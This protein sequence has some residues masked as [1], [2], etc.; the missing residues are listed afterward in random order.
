MK[1][2]FYLGMEVHL[3]GNVVGHHAMI[4]LGCVILDSEMLQVAHFEVALLLPPGAIWEERWMNTFWIKYPKTLQHILDTAKPPADAM[5][6]FVL[7]IDDMDRR[8]G[9]SLV[10]LSEK[11]TVDVAW[12]NFYLASFTTRPPLDF[13]YR[14]DS[15]KY[16]L[17]R[18]WDTSSVYHGALAVRRAK[19]VDWGLEQALTIQNPWWSGEDGHIL[20]AARN[21]AANYLLF[22]QSIQ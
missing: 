4:G 5:A 9:P 6:E 19:I 13:A 2:R 20:N 11:I 18:I 17:R 3:T 7:W 16:E 21:V 12:I 10:L 1:G 22:L 14:Y 8:Y 15:K